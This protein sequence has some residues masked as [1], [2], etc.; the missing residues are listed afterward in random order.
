MFTSAAILMSYFVAERSGRG[1]GGSPDI[2]H[3][4]VRLGVPLKM[5]GAY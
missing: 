1:G 4:Y 5:H 3:A 2:I